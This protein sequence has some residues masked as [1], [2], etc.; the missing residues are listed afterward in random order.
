MSAIASPFYIYE[1]ILGLQ[2]SQKAD[3]KNLISIAKQKLY[4]NF[5]CE[6]QHF[7]T[8][9]FKLEISRKTFQI[10]EMYLCG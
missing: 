1:L 9:K 5:V 3:I 4:Q 6:A 7:H 10:S 2:P 8:D